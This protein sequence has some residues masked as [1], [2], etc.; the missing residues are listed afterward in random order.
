MSEP[1]RMDDVDAALRGKSFHLDTYCFDSLPEKQV[2][3][4]LLS[5]DDVQNVYFT[6]VLTHGQSDFFVQYIDPET[7]T[8][9]R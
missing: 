1:T 3:T 6:G 9:R 5:L 2:F 8:V 4:D 7:N